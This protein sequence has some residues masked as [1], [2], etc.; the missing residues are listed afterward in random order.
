[1]SRYTASLPLFEPQGCRGPLC[2]YYRTLFP[3]EWEVGCRGSELRVSVPARTLFNVSTP[4]GLRWLVSPHDQRFMKAAALHD[5]LLAQGWDRL[6][7]GAIF[8]E[9]LRAERVPS[10]LRLIMWLAV[11]LYKWR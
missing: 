2:N 8:A 5:H 9:A 1:M 6:T 7:A 11:S 3:I 10:P 4:P